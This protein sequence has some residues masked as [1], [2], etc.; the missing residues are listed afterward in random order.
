MEGMQGEYTLT[1][2]DSELAKIL[3][4]CCFCIFFEKFDF[5]LKK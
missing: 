2:V 1:Q 4:N 3:A 5:F